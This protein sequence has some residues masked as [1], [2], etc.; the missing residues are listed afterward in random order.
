VVRN[1]VAVSIQELSRLGE[2][3]QAAG[4]TGAN[5]ILSIEFENSDVAGLMDKARSAAMQEARHKAEQLAEL[6]QATLGAVLTINEVS[7]NVPQSQKERLDSPE[8]AS[9]PFE[10]DE[11]AIQVIVEVTWLLR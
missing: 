8:A 1:L 11:E 4:A 7:T 2:V 10:P 3:V 9:Y 5:T 6:E